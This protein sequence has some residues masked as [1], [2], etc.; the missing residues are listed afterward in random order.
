MVKLNGITNSRMKQSKLMFGAMWGNFERNLVAG[1]IYKWFCFEVSRLACQIV[2]PLR[3]VYKN[4]C[5]LCGVFVGCV[6][7]PPLNSTQPT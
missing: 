2:G 1:V 7:K 6:G 5:W 4:L 3:D